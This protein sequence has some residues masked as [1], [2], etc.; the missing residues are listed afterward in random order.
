MRVLMFGLVF[1]VMLFMV[2]FIDVYLYKSDLF[3]EVGR[4]LYMEPGT[5]VW[6]VHVFLGVGLLYSVLM[7]IRSKLKQFGKRS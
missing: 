3:F 1:G 4:I 7:S 6:M 5:N 2:A